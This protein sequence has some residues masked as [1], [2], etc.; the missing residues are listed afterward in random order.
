MVSPPARPEA[1]RRHNLA[2]M[3]GHVH[4]DGALTR[5]ELTGRLGLSR[6]TI[7]ALVADLTDLG[8]VE[9][10][11]PSGGRRAGRP[12]HVVGP[13]PR[14]PY[15]VA[16][17]VDLTHVTTAVVGV[18][19]S[20]LARC[21]TPLEPDEAA[22]PGAVAGRVLQAIPRL[23]A[24]AD[25]PLEPVSIGVSVPGT[26]DRDRRLVV[27]APNLGWREVDFAASL[28]EHPLALTTDPPVV[29]GNDADL[30]VLAEHTRGG[31]RDCDDVI[32]LVGRIGVGAGIIANGAPVLGHFG[33]AGEI[34]HNV[35]DPAGPHCHCGK[36]GC[37]ETYVGEVALLEL[38]GVAEP[39][40]VT[41][42][43]AVFEGA[44][45]GDPLPLTAVRQVAEATGRMLAM[46]VNTLNPQRMLL[47]GSFADVLDIARSEIETAL[48]NYV[49]DQHTADV[50]LLA[51]GLGE[52]SALL[53]AAEL[54]F[55]PLLDD[56]LAG[57]ALLLR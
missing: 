40:T 33:Y 54:A 39:P 51:P 21:V 7:G 12:S 55:A 34:G 6:S 57:R 19:G 37:L 32:F 50:E 48:D 49:L 11:V 42:V 30:A 14:G 27:F 43:H 56:P 24:A 38:A 18:G 15:V 13:R 23:R 53:G 31:A 1:V 9:E 22:D 41:R 8:L 35:V 3:L 28:G 47:G 36:R 26:V 52:D 4:R 20:V 2:L 44:R 5:A 46:L 29:V 16:V 25:L 17:D 45:A 10:W